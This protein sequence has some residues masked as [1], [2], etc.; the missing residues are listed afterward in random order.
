MIMYSLI[1]PNKLNPTCTRIRSNSFL[2]A[3]VKIGPCDPM[4]EFVKKIALLS[5]A[6]K[7]GQQKVDS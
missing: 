2:S 7:F 4:I 6:T 1:D 3:L 5:I